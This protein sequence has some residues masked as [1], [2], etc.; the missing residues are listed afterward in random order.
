MKE[1]RFII[2][3]DYEKSKLQTELESKFPD[4]KLEISENED[5]VEV[6]TD[7]PQG[8]YSV[9]VSRTLTYVTW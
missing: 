4:I 1:V 2:Y 6:K 9:L 7:N 5:T 3:E 8:V